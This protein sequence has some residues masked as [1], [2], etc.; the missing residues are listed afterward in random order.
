MKKKKAVVMEPRAVSF[1]PRSRWILSFYALFHSQHSQRATLPPTTPVSSSPAGVSLDGGGVVLTSS[2]S[3]VGLHEKPDLNQNTQNVG[4]QG[5]HR[6]PQ[7]CPE[8]GAL[9]PLV[10]FVECGNCADSFLSSCH[11]SPSPS[12]ARM[13]TWSRSLSTPK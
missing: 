6:L 7:L 3:S 13:P 9:I 5:H 2:F 10:L 4:R 8:E 12:R 11:S 1:S